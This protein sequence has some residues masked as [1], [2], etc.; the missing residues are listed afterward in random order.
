MLSY[1]LTLNSEVKHTDFLLFSVFYNVTAFY[2][3]K[4]KMVKLNV[5]KSKKL[6]KSK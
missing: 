1:Y 6:P 3:N 4:K 2:S 5:I